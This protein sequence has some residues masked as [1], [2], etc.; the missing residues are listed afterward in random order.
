MYACS[1]SALLSLL[2]VKVTRSYFNT[3][4]Q[5][6]SNLITHSAVNVQTLFSFT[7]S[8]IAGWMYDQNKVL[9]SI[10]SLLL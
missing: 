4:I 9:L 8:I 3:C 10:C 1:R 6:Q 2:T 5:L 7:I